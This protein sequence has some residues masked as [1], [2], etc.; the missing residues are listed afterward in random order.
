MKYVKSLTDISSQDAASAGGKGASLGELIRAGF[1]V[2]PGFVILTDAFARFLKETK[3]DTRINLL[4]HKV[5]MSDMHSVGN[6]SKRITSL[7]K[8]RK[9]PADITQ[10]IR[11]SFDALG[12]THVAVRSSATAEDSTSAAWAGQLESYLNVTEKDLLER[13]Q[14]CWASLFTP[15]AIYYRFEKNLDKNPILV[16]VV[17]Q[18]M[19]QAD[20]SGIAFS[21]H[22]VTGDVNNLIIEAGPGLGEALSQGTITPDSYI[23]EKK[24]RRIKGGNIH[25]QLPDTKQVLSEQQ[26]LELSNLVLN[27][28]SH[29]EVP[30]DVEWALENQRFFIVQSRPVTTLTNEP[31]E[32]RFEKMTLVGIRRTDPFQASLRIRAWSDKLKKNIGRGYTTIV[33]NSD[34]EH[35]VDTESKSVVDNILRKK[36]VKTA[37]G[38]IKKMYEIRKKILDEIKQGSS[39]DLTDLFADLFTH[40][41]IARRIAENVYEKATATEQEYINR[42][43][44]DPALFKPLDLFYTYRP[45]KERCGEWSIIGSEGKTNIIAKKLTWYENSFSYK[46]GDETTIIKGVPAQKGLV[47]GTVSVVFEGT[48]MR[49]VKKGDILVS[50]MTTP[51]LLPAMKKAA[52]FVTDEGGIT[53]HAAITARE[54]KKPCIVS[55][56]IASKVL[57]DGMRVEVDA[58]QGFVRILSKVD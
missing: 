39:T 26:I 12:V 31:T 1:P 50:P 17:V 38:H 22:P 35:Y 40:F 51:D 7:I 42:W 53:S 18:E 16:A 30:I 54:L 6:T 55:T 36:R 10:E 3:N 11:E 2:P 33:I 20:A 43:R 5:D 34:G 56:G 24:S 25:I 44:N 9:V 46:E 45:Q 49:K 15:R 14:D 28:E 48:Q 13:V 32:H 23:I 29:Y 41:L 4:L 21:V 58:N 47:R 19:V 57:Q 27:I 52:A 37:T 8:N